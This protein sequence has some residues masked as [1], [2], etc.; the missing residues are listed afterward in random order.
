MKVQIKAETFRIELFDFFSK[1]IRDRK[2]I[3][4][5]GA[6]KTTFWRNFF[7]VQ[8]FWI[9]ISGPY[10][11]MENKKRPPE[12]SEG[13]VRGGTPRKKSDFSCAETIFATA[14]RPNWEKI[15]NDKVWKKRVVAGSPPDKWQVS[16]IGN[17]FMWRL[18]YYF[19]D[20]S[21]SQK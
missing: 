8:N 4:C 9:Q 12:E 7:W 6:Q 18:S 5:Q 2:I 13:D 15:K 21:A 19:S 1:K 20:C 3:F 10:C 14:V 17:T 16:L 11:H